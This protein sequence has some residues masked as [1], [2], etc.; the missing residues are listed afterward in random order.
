MSVSKDYTKPKIGDKYHRLTVIS[1]LFILDHKGRVICQCECG[2]IKTFI[3]CQIKSGNSKSCG[4][5][6]KEMS[7]N[8]GKGNI[9]H[10]LTN[11]KLYHVWNNIKDRCNNPNCV[12]YHNYGK[13]GISI[14][15][16]WV[17]DFQTFYDWS[18]NN[19]YSEKLDIDRINN[20]GNYEP[21]NCRYVT[22]VVNT[23]NRRTSKLLTYKN[24]TKNLYDWADEFNINHH[25]IFKRLRTG[26]TIE[27]AL[28][29]PINI[30]K[31]NRYAKKIN[32]SGNPKI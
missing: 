21:S 30:L 6:K 4:C 29:T 16:E 20:D 25:T 9:T 14:C 10:G 8:N 3:F 18:M 23:R 22:R 13:R 17:D 31:R 5:Y 24:Q 28:E 11:H 12:V 1:E 15:K 7:K 32:L 26:Y 2:T 19:G 27:E